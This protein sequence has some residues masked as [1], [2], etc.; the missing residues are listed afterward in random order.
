MT[1]V[2]NRHEKKG[3][4]NML[5]LN[6]KARIH[7]RVK[8]RKLC[9]TLLSQNANIA[10]SAVASTCA[11]TR[12]TNLLASLNQIFELSQVLA[13]LPTRFDIS[14]SSHASSPLVLPPKLLCIFNSQF[15][16]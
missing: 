4:L 11:T 15:F 3:S 16:N 1:I 2:K 8:S 5:H 10:A 9:P 6:V 7:K 12:A 14:A 13:S